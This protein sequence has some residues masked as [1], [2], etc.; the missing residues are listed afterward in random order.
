ML[1][2]WDGGACE[3]RRRGD[4]QKWLLT[5]EK[6]ESSCFSKS[7]GHPKRKKPSRKSRAR[8]AGTSPLGWTSY[9]P[10]TFQALRTPLFESSQQCGI[11]LREFTG[12]KLELCPRI[13]SLFENEWGGLLIGPPSDYGVAYA[14]FRRHI[15]KSRS[16]LNTRM[17]QF[18]SETA[19]AAFF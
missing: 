6:T 9:L 15:P 3:C 2:L 7:M 5:A 10:G 4:N 1:G 19:R 17:P 16:T 14:R 11:S 18:R 12:I 13:M 8:S